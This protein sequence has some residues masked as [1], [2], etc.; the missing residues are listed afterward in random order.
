MKKVKL[1]E[2]FTVDQNVNEAVAKNTKVYQI[3]TPAP[4]AMLVGELEDLF[5]DD[6]RHI[7]TEFDDDERYESVLV[8]NLTKSDIKKIQEEIG[9]VLIWEYS[10]KKGKAISESLTEAKGGQI[11]PGDYVKNQHGNITFRNWEDGLK[12]SLRESN[13][14]K[15]SLEY[16]N[17]I[18]KKAPFK[19][20]KYLYHLSAPENI[21]SILKKGLKPGKPEAS[22]HMGK[23]KGEEFSGVWLTPINDVYEIVDTHFLPEEF[24]NGKILQIDTSGLNKDRFSIG[25]EYNLMKPPFTKQEYLDK[26]EEIIYLD[27]IPPRAISILQEN[28]APNH[29]DK[30][31]SESLTEAKGGQI[32]PG[33]YVKNQHG[34]IYQRVDGKVGRQDAYVRVTNGKSGKKKTGL[35]DS[36]KLTLVNKD[37]LEESVT[38]SSEETGLMVTGRTSADNNKIGDIADNLGYHAEWNH[39]EGYWLFPEEEDMYDELEAELEKAFTKKK[40]NARFEGIFE[41][42]VNEAFVGPF[43]F[44][45][46]MSDDELKAMYNGALDGYSYYAKGMQYL[47]SD[48]KKAYQ[49]IEKI[50]KKRG[51]NLN[52]AN[53]GKVH[54]AAKQGSYPAV[55]VVVQDGKVVHQESVSTPEV[56]PATFNVMQK[57]YPKA[58]IHLEDNTGQRLFTE[59]VINEA[60]NIKK[61]T[62]LVADLGW[63]YDRM[64]SSGQQVYDELCDLLNI[65]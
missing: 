39:R 23:I 27:A 59:S 28:V 4:K 32:M 22:L 26:T 37:G 11:M 47:K 3:A 29:R 33:D 55:V 53:R 7:V 60:V 31:I 57:R 10:I 56:A 63:D 40:V 14:N 19:P 12:N 44:N 51:V 17:S 1:F 42:V 65:K 48:Y 13:E 64:S 49:E 5:G 2:Q 30:A 46:K 24:Y 25:I 21:D 43:V 8:F 61:V 6:Y 16:L 45:D 9:D 62:N 36:F 18:T 20:P 38:E 54:K 35:H 58:T 41:S 15:N 52:E 34:N 50:L